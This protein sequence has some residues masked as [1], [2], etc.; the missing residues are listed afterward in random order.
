[1]PWISSEQMQKGAGILYKISNCP[2]FLAD[3][4]L[5]CGKASF[6]G[7]NK[8]GQ[9]ISLLLVVLSPTL[10]TFWGFWHSVLPV[11]LCFKRE[12]ACMTLHEMLVSAVT[13]VFNLYVPW[14]KFYHSRRNSKASLFIDVNGELGGCGSLLT[15]LRAQW[16]VTLHV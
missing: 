13:V 11:H 6:L 16:L 2:E 12:A 9:F 3:A 8:I 10:M 1:M 5:P 14:N 7:R 4:G 15:S